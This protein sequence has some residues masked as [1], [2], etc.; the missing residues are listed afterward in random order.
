MSRQDLPGPIDD[1]LGD[2]QLQFIEGYPSQLTAGAYRVSVANVAP[3]LTAN[4]KGRDFDFEIA[5]PRLRLPRGEVHSMVPPDGARGGFEDVLPHVVLTNHALPWSRSIDGRDV[6]GLPN[7]P[8]LA[9]LVFDGADLESGRAVLRRGV[10]VDDAVD[11]GT[12]DPSDGA[13]TR[14]RLANLEARDRFEPP[15]SEDAAPQPVKLDVV[16]VDRDLF[17]AIRPRGNDTRLL[18][19]I[20]HVHLGA[21]QRN[22]DGPP[23]V[24]AGAFPI[25]VANRFGTTGPNLA[26]LVSLEGHV[27]RPDAATVRVLVFA[28]WTFTVVSDEQIRA[29]AEQ[30]TVTD[31]GF[32]E[33][34]GNLDCGWLA[35]SAPQ[36]DDAVRAL[37]ES[38]RT[39]VPYVARDHSRS[40]AV[41]RGPLAPVPVEA[42]PRT[43]LLLSGDGALRFDPQLGVFDV[44]YAAAY[45]IGRLLALQDRTFAKSVI[46]YRRANHQARH[47]EANGLAREERVTTEPPRHILESLDRFVRN[48]AGRRRFDEIRDRGAVLGRTHARRVEAQGLDGDTLWNDLDPLLSYTPED[49]DKFMRAYRRAAGRRY[50]AIVAEVRRILADQDIEAARLAFGDIAEPPPAPTPVTEEE[51]TS[52]WRP[53]VGVLPPSMTQWLGELVRLRGVPFDYL[54]PDER[55]LP[56]HSLRF[57]YIDEAWVEAL[58]AGALSPGRATRQDEAHDSEMMLQHTDVLHAKRHDEDGRE[59]R[60]TGLLL[61]SRALAGWPGLEVRGYLTSD[62]PDGVVDESFRAPVLRHE[63]LSPSVCLVLFDGEVKRVE[64]REPPEALHF[65]ASPDHAGA[66][67]H[68]I[69]GTETSVALRMRDSERRVVD[70]DATARAFASRDNGPLATGTS[71]DLA[72][73]LMRGAARVIVETREGGQR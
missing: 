58:V 1:D 22:A 66:Y 67:T 60:T 12:P 45:E 28:S 46:D 23:I 41:Y 13:I 73:W 14:P 7:D 32:R 25:V 5:G 15:A 72:E 59:R 37:L 19:H 43:S 57:F 2:G 11:A 62:A 49:R 54:V 16:D 38:G 52:A 53:F 26:C 51:P 68:T 64:L 40:A 55:T 8:W 35:R 44:S 10:S 47:R 24:Q 61:R 29:D 18:S 71:A 9:V 27:G 6:S 21:R 70:A 34:A 3:A 4:L 69:R 30:G 65:G 31:G 17:E 39:V 33:L 56:E 36:A 42:E 63:W 48:A 20:R 50:G